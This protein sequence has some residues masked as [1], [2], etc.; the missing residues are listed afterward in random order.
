MKMKV[1]IYTR[2]S[3]EGQNFENQLNQLTDF[4]KKNNWK[5]YIIYKEVVSG[6]EGNRPEF[7]KMF[8]DASQKKFDMILVWALDRF[9][10]EGVDKVWKYI[11]ELN[12]YGVEFRSFKE[13]FLNTDNKLV[14]DML[15]SIMGVLAEQERIRISERTKARLDTYKKQINSKGYFIS[16]TGN[17]I[18]HLGKPSISKKT[19]EQ[20]ISFHKE[21]KSYRDICR[22]VYYWTKGRNKK[23]V[24]MGLVHKVIKE[25][26]GRNS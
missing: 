14:K 4:C 20:I 25:F 11:K 23:Y 6:K 16:K 26:N 18:K 19:K 1:A 12:Y 2:V 17:K 13:P 3:T 15:L 8:K 5:D 24:S 22:E 10:R 9:T 7:K 21:G